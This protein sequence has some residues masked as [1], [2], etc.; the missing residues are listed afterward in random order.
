MLDSLHRIRFVPASDFYGTATFTFRAWD[1]YEG[2]SGET[3]DTSLHGGGSAF[4][5]ETNT[6]SIE[7]LPV[8]D[9]PD[10]SAPEITIIDE[11]AG[12]RTLTGWATFDAGGN[13]SQVPAYTLQVLSN[14]GLFEVLP[15]VDSAGDLT[16][17]LKADAFGST[18]VKV[19]VNDGGGTAHGGI[20]TSR[21]QTFFI[22]VRPI[23]DAPSFTVANPPD[24]VAEDAGLQTVSGWATLRRVAVPEK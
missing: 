13:E 6:A 18:A 22:E 19:T 3:A 12:A 14:P 2:V 10:F 1:K 24:P 17:T 16:Y 23:N 20:D 11:D 15:A 21:P 4:S 8:N 5:A 9:E 7:V